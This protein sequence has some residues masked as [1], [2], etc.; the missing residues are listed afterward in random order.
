L[1]HKDDFQIKLHVKVE[2]KIYKYTIS[3]GEQYKKHFGEQY[4]QFWM[5]V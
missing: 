5:T 1:S 2:I 3:F 4:K